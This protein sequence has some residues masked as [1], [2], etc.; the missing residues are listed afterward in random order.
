M[1]PDVRLLALR[2]LL[3][4]CTLRLNAGRKSFAE[5][6]GAGY[7][8]FSPALDQWEWDK[9]LVNATLKHDFLFDD[10]DLTVWSYRLDRPDPYTGGVIVLAQGVIDGAPCRIRVKGSRVEVRGVVVK[11]EG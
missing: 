5:A 4:G 10:G 8:P 2:L 7:R 1:T 6:E 3:D 9:E 11:M